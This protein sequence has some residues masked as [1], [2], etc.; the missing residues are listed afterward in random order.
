MTL[1][2]QNQSAVVD[3]PRAHPRCFGVR[4]VGRH[5]EEKRILGE[6]NDFDVRLRRRQREHH[7]VEIAG[8]KLI[9]ERLGLRLAQF[10]N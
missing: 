1:F 9:D 10:D 2:Q 7:G 5:G 6:P 3:V 4:I 8:D